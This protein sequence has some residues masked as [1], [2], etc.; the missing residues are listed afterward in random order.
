MS[1][2]HNI[3]DLRIEI[4]RLKT[5][6]KQQEQLL[7]SDMLQIKED[8]KPANLVANAFSSLTGIKLDRKTLLK[9]GLAVGLSMLLHRFVFKTERKIESKLAAYFWQL[10]EKVKEVVHSFSDE[11]SE[12]EDASV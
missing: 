9:D 10:V 6:S 4:A 7:R 3:D 2:I 11:K 1:N 8:L 12:D 5:I